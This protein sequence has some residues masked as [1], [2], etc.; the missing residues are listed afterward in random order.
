MEGVSGLPEILP[1][2]QAYRDVTLVVSM[3]RNGVRLWRSLVANSRIFKI[4][5]FCDA[6]E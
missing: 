2:R 1:A 5:V 4:A 3:L 6:I